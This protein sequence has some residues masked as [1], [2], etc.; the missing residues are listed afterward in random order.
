MTW[1][2]DY[3]CIYRPVWYSDSEHGDPHRAVLRAQ[4]VYQS[5]GRSVRVTDWQGTVILLIPG[6]Q[7]PGC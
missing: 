2:V 6:Q 4:Q 3:A 5:T 1:D 7:H